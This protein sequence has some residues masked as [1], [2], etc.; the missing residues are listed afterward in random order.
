MLQM[1]RF[2]VLLVVCSDATDTGYASYKRD[3]ENRTSSRAHAHGAGFVVA[4]ESKVTLASQA[5]RGHTQKKSGKDN[6]SSEEHPIKLPSIHFIADYVDMA[7]KQINTELAYIPARSYLHI[8]TNSS[9][10]HIQMAGLAAWAYDLEYLKMMYPNGWAG[11]WKLVAEY[12]NTTHSL[13]VDGHDVVALM[14][15]GKSC[16]ITFSGTHG[17]ADWSTNLNVGTSSLPQCGVHG[18]HE[19]FFEAFLQFMLNDAW[20]TA[21]EPYL[22]ENCSEGIHITGHSQGA[23]VG[24]PWQKLSP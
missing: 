6:S 3:K 1:L 12:V 13:M 2:A 17:L 14:A 11:G 8:V 23:A 16:V 24:A 7:A 10:I 21:F 19:G 18:V 4:A 9:P 20:T 22:A 15:K 5:L